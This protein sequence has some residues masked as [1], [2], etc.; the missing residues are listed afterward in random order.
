MSLQYR[1]IQYILPQSRTEQRR[2]AKDGVVGYIHT[3]YIQDEARQADIF[4][5]TLP[6]LYDLESSI[7]RMEFTLQNIML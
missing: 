6:S 5:I 7:C 3:I 1:A 2:V 4:T